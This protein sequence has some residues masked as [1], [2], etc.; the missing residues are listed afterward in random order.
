MQDTQA[1]RKD[2]QV[3][4]TALA[5]VLQQQARNTE[6]CQQPREARRRHGRGSSSESPEGTNLADSFVLDF[7]PPTL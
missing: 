5:G 2:G 3:E 7:W 6:A 4:S 1:Q